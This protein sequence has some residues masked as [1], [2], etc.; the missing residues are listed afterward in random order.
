MA[1][2]SHIVYLD[3]IPAPYDVYGLNVLTE[4]AFA[5]T[6]PAHGTCTCSARWTPFLYEQWIDKCCLT[7]EVSTTTA[8]T[9][10]TT[11]ATTTSMTTTTTTFT[12]PRCH[13][14]DCME[15]V[16][17]GHE[18]CDT[19]SIANGGFERAGPVPLFNPTMGVPDLW[20]QGASAFSGGLWAVDVR[21]S[22][23]TNNV[24]L[25]V[26]GGIQ[27]V[28]K[29]VPTNGA[30]FGRRNPRKYTLQATASLPP[31]YKKMEYRIQPFYLQIKA[32]DVILAQSSNFDHKD[33]QAHLYANNVSDVNSPW[34]VRTSWRMPYDFTTTVPLTMA[35]NAV[36]DGPAGGQEGRLTAIDNMQLCQSADGCD[37]MYPK[38]NK[39]SLD[40][41]V[42]VDNSGS[43]SGR[44]KFEKARTF[45]HKLRKYVEADSQL[46]EPKVDRVRVEIGTF[47]KRGG[48]GQKPLQIIWDGISNDQALS[49]AVVTAI[50]EVIDTAI[51]RSMIDNHKTNIGEATLLAIN[52]EFVETSQSSMR[53]VVIITDGDDEKTE[54]DSVFAAKMTEAKR[55]A[56]VD[57][58]TCF[59]VMSS[60]AVANSGA[61]TNERVVDLRKGTWSPAACQSDLATETAQ[62]GGP[63]TL[64]KYLLTD[65]DVLLGGHTCEYGPE[66]GHCTCSGGWTPPKYNAWID[67]CCV[68]CEITTLSTTITTKTTT[69]TVTTTTTTPTTTTTTTTTTMT[70]T[71]TTTTT[72]VI[73]PQ[74]PCIDCME[75]LVDGH[76][77]CDT[78]TL[79]NGGFEHGGALPLG[80]PRIRVPEFWQKGSG[81][82]Q[83][84]GGIQSVARSGSMRGRRH[85]GQ[86]REGEMD[87]FGHT[88]EPLSQKP[89]TRTN[90]VLILVR[91]GI[92]QLT[93]VV[94]TNGAYFGQRAPREYTMRATAGLPK[95]EYEY[96]A[97]NNFTLQILEQ[98]ESGDVVLSQSKTFGEAD[99]RAHILAN[100]DVPWVVS[101][102]WRMPYNFAGTVP[103]T[104]AINIVAPT[105]TVE[106]SEGLIAAFDDVTLCQ[107][108]DGC[109]ST[110]PKCNKQSLDV[111][112]L[113]DNSGGISDR[114]KF[115]TAR[116]FVK[117]LRTFARRDSNLAEPKVDRVRVEIATFAER[118]T[119][120]LQ[121]I[122]DGIRNDRA[123][124]DDI[125]T[126]IDDVINTA[127]GQL[128][129]FNAAITRSMDDNY[130]PNIGEAVQL[131][132]KDEFLEGSESSMRAVVVITDGDDL[133]IESD[134][135]F[136]NKM[137]LATQ[138]AESHGKTC[139]YALTSD[140][141]TGNAALRSER[142]QAIQRG[143]YS[144]S[145][146][147]VDPSETL[148]AMLAQ[149]GG[150]SFLAEHLLSDGNILVGAHACDY[151]PDDGTC[152]C[153]AGVFQGNPFAYAEWID[154]CCVS[155][156]PTTTTKTTTITTT[157]FTTTTT[158]T[159]TTPTTT[160][161]RTTAST[162]TQ[163]T[164]T[165]ACD[166]TWLRCDDGESPASVGTCASSCP[167][168]ASCDQVNDARFPH[169][170]CMF[171]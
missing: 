108:S 149:A 30:F 31:K 36:D 116:K 78:I 168:N 13:C 9:V 1:S 107:S 63:D 73:I 16:A 79:A 69:T 72:T 51:V 21:A 39:Q 84:Y 111:L 123:L 90:N 114:A 86:H 22:H 166:C 55:V 153:S 71:T 105:S 136:K 66:D 133:K 8:T 138:R 142:V 171:R 130:R 125:V 151:G 12:T 77:D 154:T 37:S 70:T 89:S 112:V 161:T 139:F 29:V 155:C 106:Q 19:T 121:I 103:L 65:C 152:T 46:A 146:C 82:S 117:D 93:G 42:L 144:P 49:G 126:A 128:F 150:P 127:I 148:N 26:K 5:V 20:E 80:S 140:T 33:Y 54:P 87:G 157:T 3:L 141:Q 11:T 58:K 104:L 91:G 75:C 44:A 68:E 99:Y 98:R 24:L 97:L 56:T 85:P 132:V 120:P 4:Y 169:A 143:A 147:N 119:G 10:T 41:L 59:Y 170:T 32:G 115:E 158:T 48:N 122:W 34:V 43:I 23:R 113:V 124:T 76:E 18:A 67:T 131:A 2:Q 40:V 81:S 57:G 50:D 62:K 25:L 45:I 167:S 92:K 134:D 52:D 135:V 61:E 118:S 163:T 160:T 74:C 15:C 156:E 137:G 27:Q 35:V 94:P 162:T 159:T 129:F 110:Y 145:V 88:H 164:T 64:A 60:D 38:C 109:L 101:T 102:T 95:E 28:T 100:G 83:F 53:A 7:C 165:C 96:M 6:G 14:E 17:D 47:A